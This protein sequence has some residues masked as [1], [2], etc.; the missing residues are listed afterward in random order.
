MGLGIGLVLPVSIDLSFFVGGFVLAVV[1]GRW[2]KISSAALTT[3]A[4]AAIV[5]EGL[6]G[7]LKPLLDVAGLIP[8]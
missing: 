8:H 4:V 3:L 2:L 5:G 6:G 1:L 7:V